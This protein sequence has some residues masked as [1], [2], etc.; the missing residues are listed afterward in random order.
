MDK[1]ASDKENVGPDYY[2]IFKDMVVQEF[3][4]KI[5][6]IEKLK[7]NN[8][9]VFDIFSVNEKLFDTKTEK[10]KKI[11][12]KYRVYNEHTVISILRFKRKKNMNISQLAVHFNISK[13]TLK[14]WM[15]AYSS[16]IWNDSGL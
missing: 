3:P 2:K 7:K 1:Q 9:T 11:Q 16:H 6:E 8:P 15:K 13:N 5:N 12:Q 10:Q 4:G 14:K